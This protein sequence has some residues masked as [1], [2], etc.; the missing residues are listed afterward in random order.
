[1]KV[2]FG[3]DNG[4]NIHSAR[5]EIFDTLE[6]LGYEDEEWTALSTYEK[7]ELAKEWCFERLDIWVEDFE[8]ITN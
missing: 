7:Y 5:T 1:M 4:A 6:D 2:K 3:C 8:H